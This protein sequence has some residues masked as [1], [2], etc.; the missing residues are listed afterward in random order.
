MAGIEDMRQSRV[1]LPPLE[2]PQ[3]AEQAWEGRG[4]CL[5][6]CACMVTSTQ[7]A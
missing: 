1:S 2:K 7:A 6:L 5:V 3:S 4:F